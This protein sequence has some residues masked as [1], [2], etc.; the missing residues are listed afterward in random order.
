[1]TFFIS[2]S[3]RCHPVLVLSVDVEA[4]GHEIKDVGT[5]GDDSVDHTIALSGEIDL[6]AADFIL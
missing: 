3:Q 4:L 2:P 1:M 6:R 5:H